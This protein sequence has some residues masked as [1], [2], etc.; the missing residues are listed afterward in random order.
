[1]KNLIAYFSREGQNYCRGTIKELSKGNTEIIAEFI[2]KAVGG[3]LFKIETVQPY[4]DDYYDCCDVAK[5]ELESN[6]RPALK[7]YLKSAE[8][9]DNIFLG[10]PNWWG[11]VP[12]AV[13]TFLESLR[14]SGKKIIPF[15][16]NEG[17]GMGNSERDL[18]NNCKGSTICKGLQ[19]R[20]TD[21]PSSEKTV[22]A[23]AKESIK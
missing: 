23:W 21:A 6:A 14:I 13:L 18:E 2:Q 22:A 5:K 16:T 17:S 19:I 8:P 4:P 11:T 20:G 9:Y 1:M 10:F 12:M 7:N 15:C 3:D